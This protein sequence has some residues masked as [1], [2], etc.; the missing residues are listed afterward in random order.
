[1]MRLYVKVYADDLKSACTTS[2]LTLKSY[3]GV[4]T[5]IFKEMTLADLK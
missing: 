1:M 5:S 2:P 4:T 3:P